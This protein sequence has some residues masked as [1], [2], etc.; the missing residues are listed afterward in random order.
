VSP[1]GVAA[2]SRKR[3]HHPYSHI[4]NDVPRVHRDQP[5]DQDQQ[6]ESKDFPSIH[7]EAPYA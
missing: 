3:L 1:R 4:A 5:D 7:D 2:A 6:N